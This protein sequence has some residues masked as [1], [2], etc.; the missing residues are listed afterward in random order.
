MTIRTV[1]HVVCIGGSYGAFHVVERMLAE[2]PTEGAA[3]ACVL[4]LILH[5]EDAAN[6]RLAS[7]LR[8]QTSVPVHE[9]NDKQALE[10]GN[11]YLAPAGYHLLLDESRFHLST[12]PALNYVRPSINVLFESAAR[13]FGGSA[14]GVV[15]SGGGCDGARGAEEIARRGGTV[16]VQAPETATDAGMPQAAIETVRDARRGTVDELVAW[17]GGAWRGTAG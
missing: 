1:R 7:L 5:R 2:L 12:E 6:E 8:A 10:A 3:G 17:V 11:V 15:L 14:A 4:V 13:A 9:P 16:L